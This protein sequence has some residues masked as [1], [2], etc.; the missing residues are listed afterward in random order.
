MRLLIASLLGL[1]V[2]SAA[3]SCPYADKLEKKSAY[4]YGKR[5]I[6]DNTE[7]AV[8][9]RLS[10]ASGKL[11]VMLVFTCSRSGRQFNSCIIS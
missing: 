5:A 9:P 1:A 4:P 6:S 2:G 8:K 3:Q 7:P 11:G 10:T